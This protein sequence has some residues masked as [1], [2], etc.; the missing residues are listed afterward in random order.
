MITKTEARKYKKIIG[1]DYANKIIEFFKKEG[2]SR[3]SG[4][5]YSVQDIRN[6]LNPSQ[7]RYNLSLELY[8]IEAVE[9]YQAL[10]DELAEKKKNLLENKKPEAVTTGS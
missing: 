6:I 9:H 7:K 3:S 10:A 1:R 5:S 8:I 2:Y 4:E